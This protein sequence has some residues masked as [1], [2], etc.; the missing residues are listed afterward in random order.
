MD[1]AIIGTG[2]SGLSAAWLLH[3]H[4]NI[5][6]YEQHD[7]AGGHS[8]TVE[9]ALHAA[10]DTGFI[11]FNDWTYPNLIKLFETL[12]VETL[13][14][15]MSFGV[16]LDDGR[17]E[18]SSDAL[19]CQS[20][21]LIRPHF[22][23]MLFDIVRFYKKAPL[24]LTAPAAPLETLGDYLKRHN[25]SPSFIHDHLLPMGSAI[26]S[27]DKDAM[28]GFPL[29]T[30]L[31]FCDNHGL[32][33]LTNRPQW[34]TVKG[35]SRAYVSRL[36]APFRDRIQLQTP[37]TGVTRMS[38]HVLVTTQAGS[39]RYDHVILASHCNQSLGMLKDADANERAVLG[40]IQ[41]ADNLAILHKDKRFMPA[42]KAAWSSWNYL[43]SHHGKVSLTY[44]M[45]KLQSFL[46]ENPDL[47]VTLNPEFLPSADKILKTI[48]YAHPV[49]SKAAIE[50]QSQIKTIQGVKRT[51]FC[52]AWC[53]YGF[54][55]DGLTSGLKVAEAIGPAKRPWGPVLE[56]SSAATNTL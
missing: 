12:G 36:S 20:K 39:K 19:F 25:Y 44:W 32:L 18:Y 21:N 15:H 17:I 43:A 8:N 6:V 14:S 24:E 56:K 51:W 1:I 10:V 30:F 48:T 16:S 41:Y 2:I 11:V 27:M 5:T 35:G 34:R 26:W 7:Y 33:L 22:Y 55:E 3:P 53:G 42:R 52:G 50:A 4:H 54:H 47:F 31:R 45:N 46:P 9:S 37:V 13:P 49:Y 23:R 38:D 40:A 29:L 28:L